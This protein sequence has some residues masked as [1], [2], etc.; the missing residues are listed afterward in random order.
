MHTLAMA[1]K[2]HVAASQGKSVDYWRCRTKRK[3]QEIPLGR[4]RNGGNTGKAFATP[5]DFQMF[6]FQACQLGPEIS[7]TC[8]GEVDARI[9]KGGGVAV[10]IAKL[11]CTAFHLPRPVGPADGCC[12]MEGFPVSPRT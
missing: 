5:I 4:Q 3:R 9:A 2:N 7:G 10:R 11:K 6:Q 12:D 8:Y 1:V